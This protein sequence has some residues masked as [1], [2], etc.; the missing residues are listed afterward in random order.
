V[1]SCG[2]SDVVDG[3]RHSFLKYLMCTPLSPLISVVLPPIL[4]MVTT[5]T[6]YYYYLLLL[7]LLCF[8]FSDN[9]IDAVPL[10][11]LCRQSSKK[12]SLFI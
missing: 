2:R 5:T 9:S 3:E 8:H 6:L 7:L 11:A 4:I 12:K 1:A 10:F